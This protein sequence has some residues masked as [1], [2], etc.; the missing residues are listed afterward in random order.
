MNFFKWSS[1]IIINSYPL[2]LPQK[3]LKTKKNKI[4]KLKVVKDYSIRN[5]LPVNKYTLSKSSTKKNNKKNNK[6]RTT[7]NSLSYSKSKTNLIGK[8]CKRK[9]CIIKKTRRCKK[10]KK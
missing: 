9:Y 3:I 10:N 5:S 2:N 1:V 7:N 4:I 8:N 6:K